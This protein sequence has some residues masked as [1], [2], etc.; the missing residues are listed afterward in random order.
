VRGRSGNVRLNAS[1]FDQPST[2]L[3]PV[4]RARLGGCS[5][6]GEIMSN[7]KKL[8]LLRSLQRLFGFGGDKPKPSQAATEPKKNR[9]SH[10]PKHTAS[11]QGDAKQVSSSEKPKKAPPLSAKKATAKPKHGTKVQGPPPAAPAEAPGEAP[12][13]ERSAAD[14]RAESSEEKAAPSIYAPATPE[15]PDRKVEPGVKSAP[16]P[17]TPAAPPGQSPPEDVPPAERKTG[18]PGASSR[19]PA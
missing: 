4:N 2:A 3:V 17:G 7:V 12:P 14:R 8:G 9:P 19:S 10:A 16:A 15:M 6:H 11:G 18:K 13:H 5:I 1:F